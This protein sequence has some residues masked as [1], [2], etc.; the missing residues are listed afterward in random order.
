MPI[1]SPIHFAFSAMISFMPYIAVSVFGA[2]LVG[3]VFEV[4]D[5]AI[6]ALVG[7]LVFI[8]FGI[9]SPEAA[10]E[11]I[12]FNTIL[13][14]MGMM[15]LVDITRKSHIFE[16]LNVRVARFTGGNPLTIL[17]L[18]V[19]ITALLSAFLDNVT[20]ILVVVP[21]TIALTKG[22]GLNPRMFVISEILFSNIGGALT[23]VGDPPNIIIGGAAGLSFNQFLFNLAPPIFVISVLV[24]GFFIVFRWHEIRPIR[25]HL[26]KLFL[27]NLLIRKIQYEFLRVV[28]KRD[29]I[30]KVLSILGLTFLGFLLH[31]VLHL[32]PH[33]VALLGATTLLVFTTK[34]SSIHEALR[35]VEWTTLIF[36]SGLFVMVGGLEHLGILEK[37]SS[38]LMNATQNYFFMLV[39]IVWVSGLV[40]MVIDNIPFVAVMV[41]VI[42]DL[43]SKLAGQEHLDLL[44]WAL[45]LGACLGGNGML[46]GASANVV[47]VDLA[48]K[49][50]VHISFLEFSKYGLP[51]ALIS[52]VVASV[53]FY[54]RLYVL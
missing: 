46:F 28:L 36:F 47:G 43:Q 8:L 44:W 14:L 9:I 32:E 20:T 35:G 2:C 45:A 3:I 27:S 49:D 5:K 51:T 30:I 29:F 26:Q 15:M 7:A 52:F 40:S 13:L 6:I 17:I 18:F 54:I 4:F 10:V 16:W 22:M 25:G 53:Y 41:P 21:I 38:S 24:L 31:G 1:L 39:L 11:S 34:H 37:I 42:V 23:L 50:G 19:V 12:D 48:K 33:I